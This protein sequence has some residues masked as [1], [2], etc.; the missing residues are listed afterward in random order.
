M[1]PLLLVL[2]LAHTDLPITGVE[3]DDTDTPVFLAERIR[4][5]ASNKRVVALGPMAIEVL[6]W[7]R[8]QTVSGHSPKSLDCTLP[9]CR[10]S[11]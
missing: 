1:R 7:D 9:G 10:N 5:L 3:V 6:W 8:A 4:L 2:D 11:R